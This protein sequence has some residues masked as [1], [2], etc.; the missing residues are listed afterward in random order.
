MIAHRLSTI[1]KCDQIVVVD[2]G[3]VKELK[4]LMELE[5]SKKKSQW[6]GLKR[7]ESIEN[8]TVKKVI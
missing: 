6:D 2:E 1:Q 5:A 7:K 8:K 3:K 4:K